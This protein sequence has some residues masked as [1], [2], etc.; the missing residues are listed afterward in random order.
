MLS[1]RISGNQTGTDLPE[2][3]VPVPPCADRDDGAILTICSDD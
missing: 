3:L 1:V 2:G